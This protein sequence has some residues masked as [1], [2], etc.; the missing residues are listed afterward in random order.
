MLVIVLATP[1]FSYN[2][3]ADSQKHSVEDTILAEDVTISEEDQGFRNNALIVKFE[4][5]FVNYTN[6]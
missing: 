1:L 6:Y 5:E 4:K 3:A 2:S